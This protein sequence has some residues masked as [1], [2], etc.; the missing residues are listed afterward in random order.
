MYNYK[1]KYIGIL[2]LGV[3]GRSAINFFS[4]YS[5]KIIGWDDLKTARSDISEA[6]VE[7]LDLNILKNLKLIDLLFISPGIKPN[8][9]INKPEILFEK[10]EDK[11]I[12]EQKEKLK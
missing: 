6:N 5:N 8:H 9:K 4:N 3:T 1:N 2:G 7:I 10:I 11:T 12:S